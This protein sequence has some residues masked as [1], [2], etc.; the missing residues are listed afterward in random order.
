MLGNIWYCFACQK[1]GRVES[2]MGLMLLAGEKEQELC[3]S[4]TKAGI[5]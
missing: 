3:V 1:L 4:K 5:L 2:R